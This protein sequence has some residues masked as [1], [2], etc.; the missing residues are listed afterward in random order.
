[1]RFHKK[2]IYLFLIGLGLIGFSNKGMA[3]HKNI[4]KGIKVYFKGK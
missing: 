2:A 4:P 3:K 1:M